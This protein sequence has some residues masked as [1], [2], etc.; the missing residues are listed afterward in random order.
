MFKQFSYY[1]YYVF[2]I[3]KANYGF[4]NYDDLMLEF[5][6]SNALKAF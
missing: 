1:I 6:K 5:F 2:K 3:M 4:Y